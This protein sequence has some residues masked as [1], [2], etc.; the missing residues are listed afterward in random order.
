M[1]SDAL[2]QE[3]HQ[4]LHYMGDEFA[5]KYIIKRMQKSLLEIHNKGWMHFC[6]D[7]LM[8]HHREK[9]EKIPN[10][11]IEEW[12]TSTPYDIFR[13][14]STCPTV[15]L[16]LDMWHQNDHCIIVCGKWIFDSNLKVALPLTQDYLNY[17]CCGN[18][19]D[20]NKFVG[21]LHAI[22]VVHP[23]DIQIILNMK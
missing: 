4:N 10:Y 20:E 7:I 6:R 12:H 22:I 9:N 16:L 2:D 15:C 11:C 8:G 23:E 1:S 17:I 19:K 13:N 5:S 18:V 21:V 3:T 14:E